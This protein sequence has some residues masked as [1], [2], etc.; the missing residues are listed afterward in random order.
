MNKIISLFIIVFL[1]S[2]CRTFNN[3]ELKFHN[4]RIYD[5]GFK[6]GRLYQIKLD[7]KILLDKLEVYRWN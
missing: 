7:L 6:N 1:C 2:G 5:L 4:K 3:T